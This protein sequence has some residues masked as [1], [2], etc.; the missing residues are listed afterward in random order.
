MYSFKSTCLNCYTYAIYFYIYI[1]F[2]TALLS[3]HDV[4]RVTDAP[5]CFGGTVGSF[6]EF[7]KRFE[8]SDYDLEL[9]QKMID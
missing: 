8:V 1:Y 7:T 2:A 4:L 3:T 5:C 9:Y 6:S